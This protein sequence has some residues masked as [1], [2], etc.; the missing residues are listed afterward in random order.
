MLA[1]LK[2]VSPILAQHT[3]SMP[4]VCWVNSHLHLPLPQV[5]HL[6]LPP[7]HQGRLDHHL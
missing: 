6:H 5:H 1:Q 2:N 4:H 7:H 3:V